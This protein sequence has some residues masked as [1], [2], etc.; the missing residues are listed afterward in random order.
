MKVICVKKN[1]N[2]PITVGKIYDILE[3]FE[4]GYLLANASYFIADNG[5][6][7]L[8]FHSDKGL[9]PLEQW[10]DEQLNKIGL[11]PLE[12]WRDEQLNKI[13]I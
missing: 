11:I 3:E 5:D 4:P 2:D 13:G 9:I 1:I 7:L 12:Q 10:R 8:Y 6:Q